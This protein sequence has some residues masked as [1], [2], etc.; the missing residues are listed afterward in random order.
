MQLT[1]KQPTEIDVDAVEVLAAVRYGE[2]D[3]PN[4]YPFRDGDTWNVVIDIETGQIHN[5]PSGGPALDLHMKVTDCGTYRLLSGDRLV[6][7]L[8]NE[9]VPGFF[10][11]E[12][13]GDYIIFN[14][15]A[16]GRITNWKADADDVCEAF[17]RDEE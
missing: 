15:D 3:M 9:Y 12:H 8:V 5:W 13:Y 4:D 14:I 7:S 16:S 10:P 1:V 17:F 11:G 2:E 6:A